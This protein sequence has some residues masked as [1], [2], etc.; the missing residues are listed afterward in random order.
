MEFTHQARGQQRSA[1]TQHIDPGVA[2]RPADG[3]GAQ[4]FRQLARDGVGG[5]EG[6]AFGR[7]VAVDD[8][9]PG[10][11]LQGAAHMRRGQGFAAGEQL[12]EA[13]QGCGVG[14]HHGVEQR[15]GEPRGVDGVAPDGARQSGRRGQVLVVQHAD[16]AVEQRP[17]DLERGGVESQRCGMQYAGVG[18]QAHERRVQHQ[19]QDGRVADDDALGRPG[20]AR[21]VHDVGR[22]RRSRGR[23]G[24]GRR[25]GDIGRGVVGHQHGQRLCE[26]AAV[27][28]VGDHQADAGVGQHE[29]DAFRRKMGIQRKIGAAGLE[30][31]Q[32]DGD[33]V[34]AAAERHADDGARLCAGMA[35]PGAPGFGARLEFAVAEHFAGM[36]QGRRFAAQSSLLREHG[37]HRA[38]RIGWIRRRIQGVEPGAL[39]VAQGRNFARQAIRVRDQDAHGVRQCRQQGIGLLGAEPRCGVT[40]AQRALRLQADG[41]R[42][43]MLRDARGVVDTLAQPERRR[44]AGQGRG[45]EL[46]RRAPDRVHVLHP[47]PR[48]GLLR[49][50]VDAARQRGAP[51]GGFAGIGC[52]SRRA[53]FVK[54]DPG[55]AEPLQQEQ[56]PG[57]SAG[58]VVQPAHAGGEVLDSRRECG[59][60]LKPGLGARGV[61]LTTLGGAEQ[62]E[63]GGCGSRREG[64]RR[65]RRLRLCVDGFGLHV[66]DLFSLDPRFASS[67][68]WRW[69]RCPRCVLRCRTRPRDV[70]TS[71]GGMGAKFFP[72]N[73]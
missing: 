45:G 62:V 4:A 24:R 15:G 25:A 1:G 33:A 39:R 3:D 54:P 26:R 47:G 67:G 61:V 21:G 55:G 64:R 70:G 48:G 27:H 20:R 51:R 59:G 18:I 57:G 49:L 7:A 37:V 43:S 66:G 23:Y 34:E 38:C 8:L 11:C 68:S 2:D 63:D 60:Q 6:G 72:S 22:G 30:Y 53:E 71:L 46:R 16:A 10:Q 42:N 73:G 28:G 40:H 65:C 14:V 50:A 44:C 13:A 32:E 17:P 12:R 35:K 58:R 52:R 41:D 31:A 36:R 56:N 9:R 5:G 29:G 69:R 19:A